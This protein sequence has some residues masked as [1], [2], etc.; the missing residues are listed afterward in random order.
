M[1]PTNATSPS[2]ID[3]LLVMAMHRTFAA[4]QGRSESSCPDELARTSRIVARLGGV[5]RHRRARPQQHPHVD[6]VRPGQPTARPARSRRRVTSQ[7][8]P[9]SRCQPATWTYERA[10][11]SASAMRGRPPRRRSGPRRRNLR[12]PP[13]H[14]LPR[15]RHRRGRAVPADRSAGA[16][17]D[18]ERRRPAQAGRRPT[19]RI[20]QV[21]QADDALLPKG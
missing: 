17:G 9:G 1:P 20:D 14:R 5:R 16:D 15:A 10:P 12:V 18:G 2:T 7:A 4:R 11:A 13:A 21:A 3:D 19:R 6:L 8:E